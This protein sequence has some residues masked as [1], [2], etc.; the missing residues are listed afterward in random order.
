[1]LQCTWLQLLKLGSIP[2]WCRTSWGDAISPPIVDLPENFNRALRLTLIVVVLV[3]PAVAANSGVAADALQTSALRQAIDRAIPQLEA[4]ATGSAKERECY[5]CH[6]QALPVFALQAASQR[7]FAIDQDVLQQQLD[8]TWKHLERGKSGYLEGTGQGG[9]AMTA[10]YA[11][12]TLEAGGWPADEV[13]E[14]VANYLIQRHRDRQHW[15]GAGQR[16]PTS[17]SSFTATYVS[18]RGLSQFGSAGQ[19]KDIAERRE[20]AAK[21]LLKTEPKD[22]EDRVFRLRTLPYIG[23]DE[24]LIAESVRE[25]LE[26]QD[27]HG[28]WS[29]NSDMQPDAY[30]TGS[31][32]AALHEVGGLTREHPAFARGCQFLLDS[33][34]P[35]GTWH[36]VTRANPIQDYFESGFPHGEDQFISIAATG[37][38]VLALV[39]ALPATPATPSAPQLT[40]KHC[41]DFEV[42]GQGDA[43]AWQRTQWVELQRRPLAV[44]DYTARFKILYSDLGVYVL[45]DGSDHR[46][47]ATLQEDF[48]DLWNEDVYECFFWTDESQPLYFEYEISPLGFELPI[49]IPN[50]DGQFLGWRPWHYDG[51]RKTRKRV[52]A[53]GGA[54]EPHAKVSHWRAEVF[55]PFELLKPLQNVPPKSGTRWRANFYRVDYDPLTSDPAQRESKPEQPKP[56]DTQPAIAK[57][58]S[59]WD[60]S[61]VGPSFH[62]Y[63]KFGTLI[64]E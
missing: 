57:P 62:E 56:V 10:G 21:W 11:L 28:G 64:F 53:S 23:A 35:D 1:M 49:L 44:H 45:F 60:W 33:Q 22:T 12:W 63:Q 20:S 25:L 6:S 37:W 16:P 24:S 40:V 38:A 42:T 31:V 27:D 30:A 7:G 8:H 18:L 36:V 9:Q 46:L 50:L 58:V 17:G 14:A 13:T 43:T 4:G 51:D 32:L 15:S 5:T 52:S 2:N 29:Q 19:Q 34:L 55:I 48:L 41:D 54:N 47:T 3:W 26:L 59:Q 39:Q 61:R